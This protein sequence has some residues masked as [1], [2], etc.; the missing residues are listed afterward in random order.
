MQDTISIMD[1]I[2]YDPQRGAFVLKPQPQQIEYWPGTG[3]QKS[4]HN[5]FNW[6][7][8][9]SVFMAHVKHRPPPPR[10]RLNVSIKASSFTVYSKAQQA[11]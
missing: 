9:P 5:V 8:K 3:I 1:L 2:K 10:S 7:N 11:K 4:K 6:Q